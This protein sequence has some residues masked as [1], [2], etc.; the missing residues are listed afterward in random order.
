MRKYEEELVLR[1][2]AQNQAGA[3]PR[4]R[5]NGFLV[6]QHL[7]SQR[8]ETVCDGFEVFG[9]CVSRLLTV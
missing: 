9:G 6:E 5:P 3:S 2:L 8:C 4:A 7:S 1:L